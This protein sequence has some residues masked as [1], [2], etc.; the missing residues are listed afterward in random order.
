MRFVLF[1]DVHLEAPFGWEGPSLELPRRRALRAVLSNI[2]SLADDVGADAV[3]CGGDLYE[4]TLA[5]SE[6]G[7]FLRLAFEAIAPIPVYISP[8]NHDWF[9]PQSLYQNVKWS[10]NVHIFSD[11]TLQPVRLDDGLTLWGGAHRAPS[12]TDGFLDTF[13]TEGYGVH[14]ALFHGSEIE[15]MTHERRGD[16]NAR[17]SAEQIP[18]SGLHHA[19]VGHYHEHHDA[20]HYTYSGNPDPLTFA[21]KYERGSAERGVVVADVKP[22]GRIHRER[23]RVA[24]TQI[25]EIIIDVSGA[26]SSRDICTLVAETLEGLHGVA[27]VT[28]EGGSSVQ[29]PIDALRELETSLDGVHFRRDPGRGI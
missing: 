27:R 7:E 8:G 26:E 9:G 1:S 2:L 25:H 15:G 29:L 24:I 20:E 17:F 3:L 21:E 16:S 11:S 22:D 14:I 10:P 5:G 12:R 23:R 18:A 19:F 4:S 6:T 13:S 28:F